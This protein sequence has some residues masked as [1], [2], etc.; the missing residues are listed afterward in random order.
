[1]PANAITMTCE[2]ETKKQGQEM[3]DLVTNAPAERKKLNTVLSKKWKDLFKLEL[4]VIHK[5]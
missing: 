2:Q 1:L 3:L 5:E 4:T